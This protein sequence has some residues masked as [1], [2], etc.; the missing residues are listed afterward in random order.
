MRDGKL[1]VVGLAIAVLLVAAYLFLT[2]PGDSG[3]LDA[4]SRDGADGLSSGALDAE[5]GEGPGLAGTGE[6]AEEA[7]A[8]AAREAGMG[9]I[10]D[11]VDLDKVDRQRD[12]HGRVVDPAGKPI[13]GATLVAH[14]F[15]WRNADLLTMGGYQE[16]IEV[17][18]TRSASDGTFSMR[19]KPGRIVG[20]TATAKGRSP[21]SRGDL[22]A[23]ER[24]RL[25]MLPAGVATLVVQAVDA[26]EKPA[27]NVKLRFFRA[28]H[29][30]GAT[31][32]RNTETD[33]AGKAVFEDLPGGVWGYLD[34]SHETLGSPSWQ[35]VQLAAE[36]ETSFTLRMLAGRTLRG[37]VTDAITGKPVV[38]ARVGMNWMADPYVETDENGQYE[39]HGWTGKGV[40]EIAIFGDGYSHQS[41]PVG[42]KETIDVKLVPA[43]QI[44]GVVVDAEGGPI[45]GALV[46]AIASSYHTGDQQ[47]SMGNTRTGDEGRFH[48]DGLNPAM[49][50]SLIVK[51]EGYAYFFVDFDP[52]PRS[53]G[54]LDLGSLELSSPRTIA[55][56]IED[57][58][59]KPLARVRVELSGD[60]ADRGR[61]RGKGKTPAQTSYGQTA[62]RRTDDLG[63]FHF[64]D[65]APG[66]YKLHVRPKGAPESEQQLDLGADTDLTDVVVVIDRGWP[67]RVRI[68]DEDGK[69]VTGVYV[70]G[71]QGSR[72]VNGE[73]NTKGEVVLSMPTGDATVQVHLW[74]AN[75][76]YAAVPH[77]KVASG[78]EEFEIVLKRA[79]LIAGV[80]LGP[81]G[82][83]LPLGDVLAV[84][85]GKVTGSTT[86]G[87]D[88][89]FRIKF[90]GSEAVD[91]EF[92]GSG[93]KQFGRGGRMQTTIPAEGKLADVEPGAKDAELRTTAIAADATVT[94]L[95]VDPDGKPL[96]GAYV[97]CQPQPGDPQPRKTGSDGRVTLEGLLHQEVTIHVTVPSSP[98][99]PLL[100]P[101][102]KK[103]LPTGQ[104]I[105]RMARPATRVPLRLE[106]P[107][108]FELRQVWV[109]LYVLGEPVWHF[110]FAPEAKEFYVLLDPR[111]LGMRVT[112]QAA[113][114]AGASAS[115]EAK[116]VSAGA[117]E[118]E[119]ELKRR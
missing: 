80:L 88:G 54:A 83:P 96:S 27:A 68:V 110:G 7:A 85:D 105:T 72:R 31:F 15:P 9:P 47:I 29:V 42:K 71:G 33:E 8:R 108:D 32:T 57:G 101:H 112:V 21:V 100:N 20:L 74:G 53:D 92:R 18:R 102:K 26:E 49:P 30:G 5:R 44:E 103:V 81:D 60:F 2:G 116:G 117:S 37:T 113:S 14:H 13:A 64:P 69:P 62:E 99:Q 40:Q 19:L 97:S 35:R 10:P 94:V 50:H 36:G 87:E 38:G 43:A 86:S 89:T 111:G 55:G 25:E 67:L 66:R 115:G 45:A 46:S 23:G 28:S 11:P 104:E 95:V 70:Q 6:T 16:K 58:D 48:V 51:A 118:I 79:S 77:Q 56:R 107:E 91:L 82:K 24:V 3:E 61:L 90:E 98:E 75:D 22:S 41:I 59:G 12:L 1:V 17:G 34:P 4:G 52:Q 78:T 119:I 109:S 63:R 93:W 114:Q 84:R 39:L 73:T 106:F 65:L 76:I